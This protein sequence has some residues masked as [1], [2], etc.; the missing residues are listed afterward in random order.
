[1]SNL[2]TF[3]IQPHVEIYGTLKF[4]L[5]FQY[6]LHEQSRKHWVADYVS[7]KRI[8]IILFMID[9]DDE[10]YKRKETVVIN[11]CSLIWIVHKTTV[12]QNKK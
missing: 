5:I 1:M 2:E 7:G 4:I 9:K 12:A 11:I 3:I 6:F 8:E 10:S